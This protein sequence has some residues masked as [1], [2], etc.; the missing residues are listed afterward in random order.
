[1]TDKELPEEEVLDYIEKLHKEALIRD[2]A[3]DVE[4]GF[5]L[6]PEQREQLKEQDIDP[7]AFEAFYSE[8]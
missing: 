3:S 5:P 1:M 4:D 7:D 8:V 6:S 2:C